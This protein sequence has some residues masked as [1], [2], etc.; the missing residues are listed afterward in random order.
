MFFSVDDYP[1]A[2]SVLVLGVT[3]LPFSFSISLSLLFIGK[4]IGVF[5]YHEGH[6]KQFKRVSI[7]LCIFSITI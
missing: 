7:S 2:R 6:Q 1:Y 4:K 3:S 5:L